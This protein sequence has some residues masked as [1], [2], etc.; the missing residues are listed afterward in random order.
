MRATLPT[1]CYLPYMG[2]NN[3]ALTSGGFRALGIM[4]YAGIDPTAVPIG[5]PGNT[6]NP[7]GAATNLYNSWVYEGCSDMPF[8]LTKPMR[9]AAAYEVSPDNMHYM[10]YAFR[11]AQ[12]D[13]RIFLSRC[14]LFFTLASSPPSFFVGHPSS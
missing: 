1:S 5:A 12:N 2:Y 9:A 3:T 8:N 11:Q 14:S 13:N 4:N 6:T 10:E 7:S